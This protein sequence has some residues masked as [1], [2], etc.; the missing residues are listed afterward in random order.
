MQI[1]VYEE[2]TQPPKLELADSLPVIVG[3]GASDCK[4]SV[5]Q[6]GDLVFTNETEDV[7]D[8]DNGSLYEPKQSSSCGT[9]EI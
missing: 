2:V 8:G 6:F 1:I 4:E 9:Y 5:V 7:D 3:A